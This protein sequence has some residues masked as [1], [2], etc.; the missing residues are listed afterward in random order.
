[1]EAGGNAWYVY[2]LECSDKSLYTGVTNSLGKRFYA[3]NSGKGA[4]YTRARLPVRVVYYEKKRDRN[5]AMRREA[6]IKGM[7]RAEKLD[8]IRKIN[9][10]V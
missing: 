6:Q 3:H 10:E 2:V 8:I 5:S 7:T 4:K 1:M 9:P